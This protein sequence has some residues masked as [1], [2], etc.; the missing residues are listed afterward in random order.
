M[1]KLKQPS[2]LSEPRMNYGDLF[3]RKL[4]RRRSA[5]LWTMEMVGEGTPV[6]LGQLDTPKSRK[7]TVTKLFILCGSSTELKIGSKIA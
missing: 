1:P 3:K 2:I 6:A 4:T 5:V 7:V